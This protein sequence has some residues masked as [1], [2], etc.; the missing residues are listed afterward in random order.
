MT[1]RFAALIAALA[2]LTG[3]TA[4][5]SQATPNLA[6]LPRSMA[7]YTAPVNQYNTGPIVRADGHLESGAVIRFDP[8]EGIYVHANSTHYNRGIDGVSINSEGRLYIDHYDAPIV[9][10]NCAPDET[11]GGERGIITGLS[12]GG[13]NTEIRFF[14]TRLGRNLDM[15]VTSDFN[16]VASTYS[17]LWCWFLQ[18]NPNANQT[19]LP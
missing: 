14:D 3:L 10:M 7:S 6:S 19:V 2:L 17:N 8:V 5:S 16:R 18:E 13:G 15:G 4:T 12:G 9:T 1:K 11:I